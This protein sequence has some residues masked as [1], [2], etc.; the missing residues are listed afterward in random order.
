MILGHSQGAR[1]AARL[2]A[3]CVEVG[4]GDVLACLDYSIF[5]MFFEEK[6]DQ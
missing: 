1:L 5:E 6:K 2:I 3:E 4:G